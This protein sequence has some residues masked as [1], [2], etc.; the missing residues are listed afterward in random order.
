M[1]FKTH[2][3]K[4]L[5]NQEIDSLIASFNQDS[6]HAVLLNHRKMN[7]CEFL[8]SHPNVIPHPIAQHAFIYD[9]NIYDLGKSL[10]HELGAFYLQE[11]SAMTVSSLL[12][13]FEDDTVLDLCAA[14][15]GKSV[16]ASFLMNNH[17][18]I[19]AND[20]SRARA[21]KILENIE[22]LGIGNTMI[23]SND[24]SLIYQNYRDTFDKIVLDA[25]C[26]GSG[27]F[28]KN[29]LI[30]MDWTYEKVLK[31]QDIQKHL[32][33]IAY[34]MLKPGGTLSYS[35]CSFSY[36]ENEEVIEHLLA[37]TDA[38]LS[39]IKANKLFYT[40]KKA[41]G[42]H[43]FPHI[44]P[45]EGH[46]IC[47]IK[48]PYRPFTMNR[49]T[50]FRTYSKSIPGCP[51]VICFGTTLFGIPKFFPIKGLSIIRYGVKIGE[52]SGN[53][54]KYDIHY[55]RY[56]D[57]FIQAT[58]LDRHQSLEYLKGNY[59]SLNN[60]HG[61]VL[62]KYNSLNIDIAKSDGKIIKNRYPKYLRK[63]NIN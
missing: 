3:Q 12:E 46:Y 4:Y 7:D 20:I 50:N 27:M 8:L 21:G 2:L 39:Q 1:N 54:I 34:E 17:G 57:T 58:S 16:Q 45:G 47:H 23:T 61:F 49:E 19:I 56:I 33:I 29:D 38:Q 31:C 18:L 25:P 15:G 41:I 22:R 11:P 51:N 36:E 59:I 43:L 6:K 55:A 26:S 24:F 40:T 30:K 9:K 44:F 60:P 28:R 10:E 13:F 53:V 48:K 62:M 37:H 32:I 52:I 35:T 42:V 5:T 14:P 63:N